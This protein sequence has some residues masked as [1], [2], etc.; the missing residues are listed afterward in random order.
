MAD[1]EPPP[2][3]LYGAFTPE[4]S[5]RDFDRLTLHAALGAAREELAQA[6]VRYY[7]AKAGF[8][9]AGTASERRADIGELRRYVDMLRKMSAALNDSDEAMPEPVVRPKAAS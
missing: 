5:Q 3:D 7:A 2:A 8:S 9:F 6:K 1:P 4:T